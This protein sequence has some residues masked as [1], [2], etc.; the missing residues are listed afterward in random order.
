MSKLPPD[1]GATT[2]EPL[3]KAYLT[4]LRAAL[5][6][7]EPA[8]R[9]E[10]LLMVQEHIDSALAEHGEHRSPGDVRAVLAALGQPHQLVS[11]LDEPLRQ[12]RPVEAHSAWPRWVGFATLVVGVLA[13]LTILFNP[14]AAAVLA[15]LALTVGLVGA[16][17]H[18]GRD[19]RLYRI[20]ASL[21]A[22]ALVL[23]VVAAV[24]LLSSGTDGPVP[25]SP[26]PVSNAPAP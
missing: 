17:L 2:E 8:E 11:T 3:V 24:M 19:R 26:M 20:A 1:A 12:I 16:R 22:A 25:D 6:G 23:L 13:V 21:G 18:V 14:I 7:A 15:V 9:E 10:V 5:A 4:E